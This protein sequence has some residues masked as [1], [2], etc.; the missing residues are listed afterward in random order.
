MALHDLM[1]KVAGVPVYELLA[2]RSGRV[3]TSTQVFVYAAGGYY[4]GT[5]KHLTDELRSYLDLGYTHVKMK[6]GGL[7]LADDLRRIDAA[8]KIVPPSHLAVDAN[9]RLDRDTA[10]AYA[11]ALSPL[12]L[13]W[14]EEPCD[15][16]DFSTYAA[17]AT[18]YTGR[19]ATGENLFSHHELHAM[20]EF[21][22]L[23]PDRA[24]IQVDPALAYGLIE[25]ERVLSELRIA[26]WSPTVCIPHGGHQLSLHAAVG[27]G[28]GGNESYPGLFAPFGGF[29]DGAEVRGGYVQLPDAPGIGIELKSGLIALCRSLA[30]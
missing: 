21:G 13:M 24:V 7:P 17:V 22:G 30:E 10:I 6:I 11:R 1:G 20:L 25:Y 16:V 26:G 14:Y 8:L 27:Y 15:P 9:G 29:A 23:Q 18:A 28:L 2:A 19:V 3:V 12:G 4:G 5:R